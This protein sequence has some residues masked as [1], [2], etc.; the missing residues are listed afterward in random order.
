LGTI[1]ISWQA[2]STD[3]GMTITGY[4]VYTMDGASQT[5]LATV[6]GLNYTHTN[7]GNGIAKSYRVTAINAVGESARSN[8][9]G[10]TTYAP[11]ST[12]TSL[13]ATPGPGPHELSLAWQA[14]ATDGGTPL[15]GYTLYRGSS[16]NSMTALAT[17][18]GATLSYVDSGLANAATF[19][20]QVT[21]SNIAGESPASSEVN[22]TTFTTPSLPRDVEAVGGI[23]EIALSWEAPSTT[24]GLPVTGY[25]VY[26]SN[27]TAPGTL[28]ATLGIQS[29][30]TDTGLGDQATWHYTITALNAAGEGPASMDAVAT[31]KGLAGSPHTLTAMA[32]PQPGQISLAW[33][34]PE[35]DGGSPVTHYRIHRATTSGGEAVLVTLGNVLTYTDTGLGNAASFYYEVSAISG[36]G[37]SARS[38]E[39]NATTFTVASAPQGVSSMAGP[40]VGQ[41]TLTWQAPTSDGGTSITGYTIYRGNGT[42]T[43]TL[44]AIVGVV[45]TYTDTGLPNHATRYYRV[46]A[47]NLAGTG[48]QSTETSSTTFNVPDAPQG[49]AV[50]PGPAAGQITLS[51]QAPT[52]DSGTPITGYKVYGG[53]STA[54]EALLATTTRL[55]YQDSSLGNA[56]TH[57]YHIA[58]TNLVGEGSPTPDGSAA[59]YDVPTAPQSVA[60]EPGV[61]QVALTWQAPTSE[62]GTPITGYKVYRTQGTG[63][64][65]LL[66][67]LGDVHAYTD[68]GLPNSTSYS[69][70]IRA[71]NLAGSGAYSDAASAATWSPPGAPQTLTAEAQVEAVHLAWIAPLSN[72]G[73]NV[74]GY[75]VYRGLQAGNETYLASLGNVLFYQ[76]T[77]VHGGSRYYYRVSAVNAVGEGIASLGVSARPYNLVL[78]TGPVPIPPAGP[79]ATVTVCDAG[80]AQGCQVPGQAYLCIQLS[81]TT[82][83]PTPLACVDQATIPPEA[84]ILLK[85]VSPVQVAAPPG[86][87]FASAPSLGVLY[88]HERLQLVPLPPLCSPIPA[89]ASGVSWLAGAG[90]D[91]IL[92]IRINGTTPAGQPLHYDTPIPYLGQAIAAAQATRG[93]IPC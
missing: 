6:T 50:A 67:T 36:V 49:F 92:E 28:L 24:G 17:L 13:T 7:L 39:A 70:R 74:T 47:T 33:Q 3:G 12:P 56:V 45:M 64:E 81:I 19:H 21:A 22:A 5:L 27:T 23:R 25:K 11:P 79:M 8:E 87:S 85:S 35:S 61:R 34:A 15:T 76:D 38:N 44:H 80:S 16:S 83:S 62:G 2:P 37:E 32:G 86:S 18:D 40:G 57:Y 31:T 68:S 63:T 42:G 29:D 52:S 20:Y 82:G 53:A 54:T 51:W 93:V 14:P 89:T 41:I 71:L 48:A 72:G 84:S 1:T 9:A 78:Q 58:A 66:T 90:P 69:Y 46:A 88:K 10:A 59:T 4:R 26:R 30:Y 55:S 91:T 43:E 75:T 60:A 73:T 65:S 77:T